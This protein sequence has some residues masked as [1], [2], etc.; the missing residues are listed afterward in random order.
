LH[1]RLDAPVQANNPPEARE[2]LALVWNLPAGQ[3]PFVDYCAGDPAASVSSWSHR[4]TNRIRCAK[5]VECPEL[6]DLQA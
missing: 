2:S 4:L 6:F 1:S 5:R 3:V